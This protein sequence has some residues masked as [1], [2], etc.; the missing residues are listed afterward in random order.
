[1]ALNLKRELE[2][3]APRIQ[4]SPWTDH[5][6]VRGYGI[7][8]LPLSS[9]HVLALRVFP[10]NDF[11]PYVT[12]WHQTPEGEWSIYYDAVSPDIACPRYYGEAV[13]HTE[14]A[15]ISVEWKSGSVLNVRMNHPR[16]EWT[17]WLDEPQLMRIINAIN[18][19]MPFWTWKSPLLLR[20]R[21]W[22][23]GVLGMGRIKL[24]GYM[25]SGHFGILMPRRMYF[26]N[27]TQIK[28]EGA[29]L[30]RPVF[31]KPNPKIGEVPLPAR[32]VFAIGEAFWEI[33]DANEYRETRNAL[34]A[35]S[36]VDTV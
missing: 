6:Y 24:A 22:M 11:A 19:R 29:D 15:K 13:K 27:R 17:V 26:I 23:A 33:L 25:P 21:E 3:F 2:A 18:N 1:M 20:L 9:G 10:E 7:F 30:G 35:N 31:A 34:D 28:W 16:L 4:G 12:I 14:A 8:G 32:G 36:F 5:E